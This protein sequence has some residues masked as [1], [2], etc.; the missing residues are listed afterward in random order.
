MPETRRA[1]LGRLPFFSFS[2]S[3][4]YPDGSERV[5]GEEL[6]SG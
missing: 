5:A 4:R 3:D 6:V 1:L 2:I